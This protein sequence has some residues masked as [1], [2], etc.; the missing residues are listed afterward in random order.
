VTTAPLVSCIIPVYNGER[1][2]KA[3]I[4]SV[5]AQSHQAIEL[6]VVDD[7]S[8]DGTPTVVAAFG[9]RVR[10]LRQPQSGQA[11][12][13]NHGI[14]ESH[15][16]FIGFL[17]ADDLWHPDKLAI[18][19]AR[20]TVEPELGYLVAHVQN[21]WEDELAAEA[22]WFRDRPRGQPIPGFVTGTLLARRTA[23]DLAGHFD[24]SFNHADKT[25]WFMR[26][27]ARGVRHDLL[28]EVLMY[29]RMHPENRSRTL[30]GNSR[31]EYL[32]L[33]KARLDGRRAKGQ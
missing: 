11:I 26:A 14:R 15:G 33:L 22:Q 19:L 6:I 2:L 24:P 3:S 30:A 20:F 5:L 13:R 8:T 17:D 21:F 16:E 1:F 7:G 32:R 12:A 18:Q 27:G 28:P 31:D 25:E 4:E 10:Y 23:F 9:D 29:R